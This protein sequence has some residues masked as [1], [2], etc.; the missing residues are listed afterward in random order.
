MQS[1]QETRSD[2]IVPT[3]SILLDRSEVLI[4]IENIFKAQTAKIQTVA[5][6]GMLPIP[7]IF[8]MC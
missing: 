7:H 2:L 5:L 3:E 6:V 4:E 8:V 1:T